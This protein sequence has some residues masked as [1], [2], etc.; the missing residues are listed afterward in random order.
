MSYQ[1]AQG[2]DNHSNSQKLI[3]IQCFPSALQQE[4]GLALNTCIQQQSVNQHNPNITC[5]ALLITN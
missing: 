3:H 2:A 4:L 5:T 1:A